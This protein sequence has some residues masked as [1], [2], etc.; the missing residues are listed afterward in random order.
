M[1]TKRVRIISDVETRIKRTFKLDLEA[2]ITLLKLSG[3]VDKNF[4]G[5]VRAYVGTSEEDINDDNPVN[6]EIET[7][8]QEKI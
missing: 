1:I 2:L 7:I 8:T 3:A 6:V 4:K 5:N